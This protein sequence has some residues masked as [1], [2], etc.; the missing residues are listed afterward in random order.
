VAS[1]SWKGKERE[2]LLEV[3]EE[4]VPLPFSMGQPHDAK[5]KDQKKNLMRVVT[6]GFVI[7]H[8]LK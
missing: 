3:L 1:K 4:G 5:E 7:I 6:N 8:F 2:S